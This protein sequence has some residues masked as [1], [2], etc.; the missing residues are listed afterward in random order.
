MGR[1][2]ALAGLAPEMDRLFV[3]PTA[4]QDA[5]RK[6]GWSQTRTVWELT[7][8]AESR[9]MKLASA[10]SLKTAL[11]RWENGHVTPDYYRDLLCELF[12][13]TPQQLLPGGNPDPSR[14]SAGDVAA[15]T[16]FRHEWLLTLERLDAE[17]GWEPGTARDAV[18]A[19]MAG[20]DSRDTYDRVGARR[21]VSRGEIADAL[22]GYYGLPD[23]GD[24]DGYH[25]YTAT[26]GEGEPI[27]TSVLT[28]PGWANLTCPLTPATD[29]LILAPS[30]SEGGP[31]LALGVSDTATV[32][33]AEAL[34]TNGRITDAPLY[35]LL[36]IAVDDGTI[37]GSVAVIPFVRY[38]LTMDLLES[39]L[40]DAIVARVP[41]RP[42]SLPLRDQYLPDLAAVLDLSK[43]ICVGGIQA[44]VAMARPANPERGP[45]DYAFLIQERSGEV[46]NAAGRLALVP[47]S[48]HQPMTDYQ[49]DARM[50]ATLR[51]AMEH[52]LFRRCDT[53]TTIA[54]RRAVDPMHPARLSDPM[55][56][57]TDQPERMHIE[58][59]GIGINLVSG[60]Y[61]V[62]SRV[63]IDP[64]QFWV[65][66][67]GQIEAGWQSSALRVI[68]TRDS[69]SIS[70]LASEPAWSNEGLFAYLSGLSADAGLLSRRGLGLQPFQTSTG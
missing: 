62:A 2:P 19:C 29:Q 11:S 48:F 35:R 6:L 67:G 14:D 49:A 27:T 56:W 24:A 69:Q 36:D 22:A 70:R 60:N 51:R 10:R 7:R 68:S 65:R 61:E 15:E 39:E 58:C 41:I 34:A 4:L 32:R 47:K 28:R 64:E 59:T 42:G 43:R 26:V 1:A 18:T 12:H 55:R 44:L 13:L 8:L 3:M 31:S 38:A 46:V 20:L 5:R 66:Y 54:P 23:G 30:A 9:E 25:L 33:L 63:I 17:A 40:I 57:L 53:D 21:R 45:A 37:R 50:T 52:E 16:M